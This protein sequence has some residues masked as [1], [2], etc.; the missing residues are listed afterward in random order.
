M[1]EAERVLVIILAATLS[2]VLILSI[3]AIIKIIQI[4]NYIKQVSEKAVAVAE[5]VEHVGAFF[6]KTAAPVA[7]GKLIA[8]I[9][10]NVIKRKKKGE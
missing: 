3:V 8:N 2:F 1:N 7:V 4:L 5:N 6:E 10:E 9:T